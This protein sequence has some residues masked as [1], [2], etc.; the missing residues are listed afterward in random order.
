MRSLQIGVPQAPSS[1]E[2]FDTKEVKWPHWQTFISN[3][4]KTGSAV[5]AFKRAD[6]Q[7]DGQTSNA[8]SCAMRFFMH[9]APRTCHF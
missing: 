4:I 1:R 8:C 3:L 6:R 2:T 7:K 5:L 9:S